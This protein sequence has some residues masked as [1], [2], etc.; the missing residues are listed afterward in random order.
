MILVTI[1]SAA[2]SPRMIVTIIV[3]VLAFCAFLGCVTWW[4]GRQVY[5]SAERAEQDPRYLR[6]SLFR[7]GM[8][9]VGCIVLLIALAATGG[10]RHLLAIPVCL[11]FAWWYFRAAYRVKVPPA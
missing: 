11:A 7:R 10:V 1:N 3:G 2:L 5:Q 9:C 4:M 8:V 6:R